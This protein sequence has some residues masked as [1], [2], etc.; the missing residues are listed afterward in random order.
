MLLKGSRKILLEF[1]GGQ[2]SKAV[3]N[4]HEL[5]FERFMESIPAI[6]VIEKVPSYSFLGIYVV[7]VQWI[8]SALMQ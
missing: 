7:T 6:S 2:T 1:M 4:S 3:N 5:W 8:K